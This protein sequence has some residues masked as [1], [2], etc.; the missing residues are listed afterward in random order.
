MQSKPIPTASTEPPQAER[1]TRP[2][3][4]DPANHPTLSL[5]ASVPGLEVRE[6]SWSEWDDAYEQLNSPERATGTAG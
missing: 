2:R 3:H 1:R 4:L 6:S 5:A